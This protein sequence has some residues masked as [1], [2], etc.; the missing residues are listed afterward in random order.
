MSNSKVDFGFRQV[1][2][3]QKAALVRGVFDSV[4]DKYDLMNDLMS[5]G[6]HRLWKNFVV[7]IS[8]VHPGSRV[9]D[10]AAGSGDLAAQFARKVGKTG[11]VILTDINALMLHKGRARMVDQGLVGNVQY[12][13]SDAEALP[14]ADNYFDCVCIGF[15]L[16]NVT[17]QERALA[18]MYACLRPGGRLIVLEFSKP[19]SR[20]LATAYDIYSFGVL[21]K[22]GKLVANDEASYKYLVESI[23]KQ[24]TQDELLATMQQVGFERVRFNNLAGGI[25]AV[26]TGYKF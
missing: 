9:L 18:S 23:R 19:T 15:G 5:F 22:L 13:L 21:P 12:V 4:V 10:V 16:R 8:G 11:S 6:A 1:A 20:L 2:A 17:R 26:H 7:Q 14:F 24:P 3:G 25:V